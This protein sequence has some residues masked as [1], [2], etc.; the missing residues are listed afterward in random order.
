MANHNPV[1]GRLARQRNRQRGDLEALM[2]EVWLAIEKAVESLDLAVTGPER[3]SAIHAISS[4]A[5]TYTKMLQV[6]EYEARLALVEQ[7]LEELRTRA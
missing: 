2:V 7:Q 5:T 4:I 1:K 6:G 3:C